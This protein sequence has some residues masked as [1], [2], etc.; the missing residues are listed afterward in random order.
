MPQ[1]NGQKFKW[2]NHVLP[3]GKFC[4]SKNLNSNYSRAVAKAFII[5]ALIVPV[6]ST[7][8]RVC[9][10]YKGCIWSLCEVH[11]CTFHYYITSQDGQL[12]TM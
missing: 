12:L 8:R 10:D 3:F 2:S 4:I 1:M 7:N 9:F 6:C 11:V 5:R